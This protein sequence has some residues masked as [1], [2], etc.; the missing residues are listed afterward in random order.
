MKTLSRFPVVLMIVLSLTLG[1]CATAP[2]AEAPS[3]VAFQVIPST[4]AL[5]QPDFDPI[6][7]AVALTFPAVADGLLKVVNGDPSTA[8][9][10]MNQTYYLIFPHGS[11]YIVLVLDEAKTGATIAEQV[12]STPHSPFTFTA[13]WKY[14]MESGGR[15]ITPKDLPADILKAA[16]GFKSWISGISVSPVTLPIFVIPAVIFDQLFHPDGVIG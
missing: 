10:Q 8:I 15:Q 7:T 1:A 9:L 4:E 6:L 5:A 16:T 2:S 13:L 12:K 3:D 11:N 14:I